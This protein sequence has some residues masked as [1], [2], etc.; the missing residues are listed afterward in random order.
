MKTP[1]RALSFVLFLAALAAVA[2]CG[3]KKDVVPTGNQPDKFL[4]DRGT[5]QLQVKH[6][7]SAREYFRRILDSYPQSTL[8]PEAKLGLAD[9]YLGENTSESMTLAVNEYLASS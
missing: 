2:A 6:W 1:T 5:E 9:S 7:L 4:F 8:R 3:P